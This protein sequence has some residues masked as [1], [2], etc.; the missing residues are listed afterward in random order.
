MIADSDGRPLLRTD[1]GFETFKAIMEDAAYVHI[2]GPSQI[3]MAWETHYVG[4]L[5]SVNVVP[6]DNYQLKSQDI[7][8]LPSP[9]NLTKAATVVRKEVMR[10]GREAVCFINRAHQ[11]HLVGGKSLSCRVFTS[12]MLCCVQGSWR[13]RRSCWRVARRT[14][15]RTCGMVRWRATR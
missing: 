6:V 9:I 12:I 2:H 15:R 7:V 14:C 3:R 8:S 5:R 11:P 13:T 1:A 10:D 4:D